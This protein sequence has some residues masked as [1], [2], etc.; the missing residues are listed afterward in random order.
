[1]NRTLKRKSRAWFAM[2][3]CIVAF[4]LQSCSSVDP[5][6]VKQEDGYLYGYGKGGSPEEA[7][8]EAKRDLIAN[9][10]EASMRKRSGE[11]RRVAVTLETARGIPLETKRVA[12]LKGADSSSVTLRVR[13]EDWEKFEA[14]RE[15][16]LR[17][18]LAPA[19]ARVSDSRPYAD[20]VAA[21]AAAL[22]RLEIAGVDAVLTV[23]DG[24]TEILSDAIVESLA[25]QTAALSLALSPSNGIL[26]ADSTVTATL[27]DASGAVLAG[28]PLAALWSRD[29]TDVGAKTAVA[30][31]D[32][33]GTVLFRV[34]A[35]E[36]AESPSVT[37]R[38]TA[39]FADG[40]S[41]DARRTATRLSTVDERLSAEA[42]F[43]IGD[44]LSDRFGPFVRVESGSF[45]MGAVPGDKRAPKREAARAAETGA[46]E[47]AAGPVTN[48]QYRMFLDATGYA[49]AP[50]FFDNP[51]YTLADQP[52][53]GIT[54]ADAEAFA[55][56][57]SGVVGSA[58]RL[59]SEAEWEKAAKA[60]RNVAF[61][62]G[63]ESASDGS[64]ANCRGNGK[65]KR[66]SPVG[67][68]PDGANPWG[69]QDMAGNVWE[70]VASPAGEPQMAKGG[71]WMEGPNDVRISNRRE[72]DPAKTYA[73]V[74]FRVV[75]EVK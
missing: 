21:A 32:A 20:R 48:A 49:V 72:T 39:A 30:R 52:V 33:R 24:K 29:G 67:S 74:G 65:F 14:G 73:D 63:D 4:A 35:V 31:T 64:R 1:M 15:A 58:V 44:S 41:A 59:P 61:P 51:E 16:S 18:E 55:S 75:M 70:L 23:E 10:L 7:E 8:L 27:T 3:S 42:T 45:T 43:V 34:P 25:E 12:E 71:S 46:Y 50:D 6:R 17:K 9:G 37:L 26:S 53:V 2:A 56:W 36:G 28:V 11:S 40:A 60:G 68:F 38:V 62:W 69:M 47:I 66:P 57:L 22:S 19:L 13:E 54:R 5:E